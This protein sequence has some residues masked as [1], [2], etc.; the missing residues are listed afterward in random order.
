LHHGL[1]QWEYGPI[2]GGTQAL[3]IR[4]E[5]YLTFFHSK[6]PIQIDLGVKKPETYFMGAYIFSAHPPFRVLRISRVPILLDE[7]YDGQWCQSPPIDYVVY[8]M[9]FYL[10][11]PAGAPIE[12]GRADNSSVVVLSMGRNDIYGWSVKIRLEDLEQSFV[13][14]HC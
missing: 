7:F 10:S 4:D 9:S 8:P 3:L 2:R 6:K 14:Y 1:R 5:Y 13:P 12:G 11:T